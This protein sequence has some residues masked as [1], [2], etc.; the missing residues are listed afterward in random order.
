MKKLTLAALLILAIAL[1]PGAGAQDKCGANKMKAVGKKAAGKAFCIAK[2]LGKAVAVDPV[3]F[4]RVEEKF[5]AAF[6]KAELKPPCLTHDDAGAIEAKVDAFVVD[7]L[8]ELRA[9]CGDG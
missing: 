5:S 6:T 2:A 8:S 7:V 3:C 4:Q 1:P 9:N